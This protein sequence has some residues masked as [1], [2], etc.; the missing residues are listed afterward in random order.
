MAADNS[1]PHLRLVWDA[2]R[3]TPV[4]APTQ[5]E[6]CA[7]LG[8]RAGLH[9][10][11]P[12]GATFDQ[13]RRG[14]YIS[15]KPRSGKSTVILN[16]VLDDFR[17][18]RG[19]CVVDPHGELVA[20]ILERLPI[21]SQHDAER[22]VVFD[23]TYTERPIGIDLLD[24]ADPFEEDLAIQFM[25]E[26]IETLTPEFARG[27]MLY[28]AVRNGMRLLFDTD[29]RLS[30][31]PELVSNKKFLNTKLG[32][33]KDP[34]VRRYWG[35]VWPDLGR[36]SEGPGY[37]A[38]ITSKF[39]QFLEDRCLR[40]IFGQRGG[41]DFR[42]V[43]ESGQILLVDLGRG[44][45]GA[46]NSRFLGLIILH[47]VE[48]AVMR[49]RIA[50]SGM[51]KAYDFSVYLDEAH[52][53]DV[54]SLTRMIT[55]FP[56]HN[57]ALVLANQALEDL[58]YRLRRAV[59]GSTASFVILRQGLEGARALEPLTQP[60]FDDSDLMRLRDHEA[61]YRSGSGIGSQ[62]VALSP[63]PPVEND[64][65]TVA[66]LRRLAADRF[67]QRRED[68]EA[69]ILAVFAESRKPESEAVIHTCMGGGRPVSI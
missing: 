5:E 19:A 54:D 67:G 29:G 53:L 51:G 43:I 48:R 64:A 25:I 6:R 27:P 49:G 31:L 69:E 38:Y 37:A 7:Q 34:F 12:V 1:A 61:V 44:R 13:L 14:L 58:P 66:A 50:G 28:Q 17:R 52:E 40:N 35:T 9:G 68:V 57:A 65:P 15:G 18:G 46:M 22:V 33:A 2:A 56:K 47:C 55:A 4:R 10:T 20:A 21:R 16:L 63:P 24:A 42:R 11:E 60:R 32:G 23:P 62:R 41:L 45:L 8:T 36:S 26:L 3:R 30:E 59:L 39:S